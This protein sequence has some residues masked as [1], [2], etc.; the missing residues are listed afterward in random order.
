[1]RGAG[2]TQGCDL[3]PAG[4]K[5]RMEAKP[6]GVLRKQLDDGTRWS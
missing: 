6:K 5:K 2:V 4:L 3:I 1:M